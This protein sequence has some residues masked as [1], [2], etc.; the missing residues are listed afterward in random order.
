[1]RY[2]VLRFWRSRR[3]SQDRLRLGDRCQHRSGAL[4][5]PT[6]MPVTNGQL[7]PCEEGGEAIRIAS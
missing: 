2:R 4:D 6:P 7:F 3:Q 1:M 5:A